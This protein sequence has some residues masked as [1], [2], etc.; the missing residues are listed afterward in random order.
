MRRDNSSRNRKEQKSIIV[1]TRKGNTINCYHFMTHGR[2]VDAPSS[3][4]HLV[5]CDKNAERIEFTWNI[6][7]DVV[8][9]LTNK[10]PNGFDVTERVI[11]DKRIVTGIEV[12]TDFEELR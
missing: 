7:G 11:F 10:H 6:D 1:R 9:L 12:E 5:T 3:C 8:I 4:S 2:N